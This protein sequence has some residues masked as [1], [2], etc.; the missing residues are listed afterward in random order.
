MNWELTWKIIFIAVIAVFAMM[1]VLVTI[2]GAR[3]IQRL[4]KHL[5][6]ASTGDD[7]SD[8]TPDG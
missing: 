5:N 3:D 4:L 2:L 6:D 1:S 7:P 8:T